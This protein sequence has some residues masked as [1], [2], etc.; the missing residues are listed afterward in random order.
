[1]SVNGVMFNL[2]DGRTGPMQGIMGGPKVGYRRLAVLLFLMGAGLLITGAMTI[3]SQV[4]W[5]KASPWAPQLMVGV[6]ASLMVMSLICFRAAQ[7][8]FA[9]R[10]KDLPRQAEELT[11]G[12]RED[13]LK[14]LRTKFG[15][16]AI[17]GYEGLARLRWPVVDADT[18]RWELLIENEGGGTTR[19]GANRAYSA[20]LAALYRKAYGDDEEACVGFLHHLRHTEFEEGSGIWWAWQELID[21]SIAAGMRPR[22]DDEQG[23]GSRFNP[24]MERCLELFRGIE[25][26]ASWGD[27]SISRY[28]QQVVRAAAVARVA[29]MVALVSDAA[30]FQ[31]AIGQLTVE[32]QHL[33]RPGRII[34]QAIQ[35]ARQPPD[36][37]APLSLRAEKRDLAEVMGLLVTGTTGAAQAS[38]SQAVVIELQSWVQLIATEGQSADLIARCRQAVADADLLGILERAGLSPESLASLQS[39][40]S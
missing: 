14:E 34:E 12:Q 8:G 29:P 38:L 17:V 35:G 30:P 22:R 36:G 32:A 9:E 19:A 20:R 5:I 21:Q 7:P 15:E 18:C 24:A 16:R 3:G 10:L 31:A 6:G 28:L 37:G 4:A 26:H 23:E 40:R 25:G 39:L 27:G 1:M 13:L 33:D 11:D 2:G